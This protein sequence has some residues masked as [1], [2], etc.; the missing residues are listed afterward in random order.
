MLGGNLR[1]NVN[2]VQNWDG[3]GAV[4]ARPD[5]ANEVGPLEEAIG[6]L[7]LPLDSA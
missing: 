7:H 4:P 6:K 2:E 5:A 3:V 1:E